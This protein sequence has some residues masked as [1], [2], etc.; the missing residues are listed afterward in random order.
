VLFNACKDLLKRGVNALAVTSNITDLPLDNYAA[1]FQGQHPNPVGGAEAVISHIIC[2]KYGVP[3][4]HAPLMNVK[5]LELES[6]IVDARGAGEF[7]SASGLA[8]VLIGLSRAPQLIKTNCRPIKEAVN[9]NNLLAVVAPASALGG[10]PVIYAEKFKIPII[11]VKDNRTILDV[12]AKKLNL[13]Q[14]IPV[15]NYPEAAGIL[16]AL[17]K[18]ISIPSLLRPLSTLR[19]P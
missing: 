8:C 3:A 11:A 18:G 7:S 12:T 9:L 19:S 17:R 2:K 6:R 4:A 10:I 15:N 1:H 13:K 16:Q 5:N 14:V